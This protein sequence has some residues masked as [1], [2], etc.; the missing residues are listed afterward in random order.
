MNRSPII[1]LDD[2]ELCDEPIG[3]VVYFEAT[4]EDI[5]QVS[6]ATRFDPAEF[7]SAVC[8]ADLLLSGDEEPPKTYAD[9]M[10]L[11]E[12]VEVWNPKEYGYD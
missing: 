10:A 6:C 9:F 4:I 5:V 12:Q 11:A 1:T 3:R 8:T 7:A 2:Y